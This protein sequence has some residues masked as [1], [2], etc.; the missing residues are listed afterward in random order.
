MVDKEFFDIGK[1]VWE[2]VEGKK[3]IKD[4]KLG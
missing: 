1:E 2:E 3:M 4:K